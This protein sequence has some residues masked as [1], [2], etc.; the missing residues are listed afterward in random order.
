[1]NLFFLDEFLV[2]KIHPNLSLHI[3]ESGTVH[4]MFFYKVSGSV[5]T[6]SWVANF[7]PR[8]ISNLRI[9]NLSILVLYFSH[10]L[11]ISEFEAADE[12]DFK[13]KNSSKKNLHT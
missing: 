3:D 4:V 9:L 8:Q 11:I 12:M 5:L 10:Y 2:I 13:N 7:F 6:D 1:M